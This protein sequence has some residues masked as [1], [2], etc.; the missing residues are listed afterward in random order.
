MTSYYIFKA[1]LHPSIFT[2]NNKIMLTDIIVGL[3]KPHDHY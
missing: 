3:S 2:H 1:K